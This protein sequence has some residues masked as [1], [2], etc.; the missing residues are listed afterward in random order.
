MNKTI[1]K[2]GCLVI[3]GVLAISFGCTAA[4][5]KPLPNSQLTNPRS[6]VYPN[7]NLPQGGAVGIPGN[8]GGAPRYIS[9]N[10]QI[11]GPQITRVEEVLSNN[12]KKVKGVN[13]ASVLLI[14]KTALVGIDVGK[15]ATGNATTTI[16]NQVATKLKTHPQVK[17][18]FVS[19]DP[20]L[21]ERIQDVLEGRSTPDVISDL[22]NRMK[23][24]R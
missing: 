8:P 24:E 3:S 22:Y 15:N 12:A 23:M 2:I 7:V 1:K 21:L 18:V 16:K 6:N 9:P 17:T 4:Q 19:S 5:K 20:D 10:P 14:G 13:D 11:Q